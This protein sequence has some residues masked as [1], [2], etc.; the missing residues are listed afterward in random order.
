M[1][2]LQLIDENQFA[3]SLSELVI[4]QRARN[5]GKEKVV[6]KDEDNKEDVVG[7]EVLNREHLVVRKVIK[8][9]ENVHTEYHPIQRLV[10]VCVGINS[11]RVLLISEK[12]IDGQCAVPNEGKPKNDNAKEHDEDQYISIS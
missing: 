3:T 10:V 5:N 8:R 1:L 2:L 4:N 6:E 9:R 12:G 7:F 11:C